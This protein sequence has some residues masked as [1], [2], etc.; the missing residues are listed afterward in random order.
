M[1]VPKIRPTE[2]FQPEIAAKEEESI[3]L[4]TWIFAGL[5]SNLTNNNDF[6]TVDFF[7]QSIVVQ[8]F[9]GELRA[10]K[11]VC[12]HRF[13][14]LQTVCR[15]NRAL[16][17]PY[18]AWRFNKDGMPQ[19]IPQKPHFGDLDSQTLESLRL[20]R[21]EVDRCGAF[22]FVKHPGGNCE[23]L[24]DYLG[25]FKQVL[26]SMS[27]GIGDEI[28]HFYTDLECNWKIAVENTLESYH[29]APVHPET[30]FRLGA[31]GN[32]FVFDQAHSSW[33]PKLNQ[34]AIETWD[35]LSGNF[36]DMA[37]TIDGYFH[38]FIYPN[39]TIATTHGASFSVQ[40][41]TPVFAD[42]T[43]FDSWVM[44][45]RTSERSTTSN[46]AIVSAM[47]TSVAAFNRKVFT[48][49]K[50]ICKEVQ[51]GVKN[52]RSS[53]LLSDIEDRVHAF[54]AAYRKWMNVDV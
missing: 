53:G 8:N 2:Y 27:H 33:N 6:V 23:N 1:V 21:W 43:R 34:K 30:F 10:F 14:R 17:C 51:L 44:G 16:V 42:M 18:H 38:V 24:S 12:T 5:I 52:A 41:F 35:R 9:D 40:K 48:E 11:N 20:P 32:E 50:V 7:G 46:R 54:Q 3:F 15:G 13:S 25:K 19:G 31:S 49:D 45:C 39:L 28:D 29:V 47:N 22:V 26:E 36:L 4:N 37:Y